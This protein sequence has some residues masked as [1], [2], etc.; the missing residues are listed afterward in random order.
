MLTLIT[1]EYKERWKYVIDMDD[2]QLCKQA[3]EIIRNDDA[4]ISYLDKLQISE[5]IGSEFNRITYIQSKLKG[6]SLSKFEKYLK[7]TTKCDIQMVA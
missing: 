4:S 3:I 5:L 1:P 7:T 6:R 2:L